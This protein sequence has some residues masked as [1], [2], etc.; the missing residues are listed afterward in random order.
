MQ[1]SIGGA[2][3]FQPIRHGLMKVLVKWVSDGLELPDEQRRVVQIPLGLIRRCIPVRDGFTGTNEITFDGVC[4]SGQN[5]SQSNQG[6]MS[7]PFCLANICRTLIIS[8]I[9]IDHRGIT[10]T[11]PKRRSRQDGKAQYQNGD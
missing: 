5:G 1:G 7:H 11:P 2:L 6:A 3:G 8:K 9:T 4:H 10:L